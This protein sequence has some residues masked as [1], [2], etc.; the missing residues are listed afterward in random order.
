M[1]GFLVCGVDDSRGAR[2]AIL[3]AN[4]IAERL[5]AGLVLVHVAHV[6]VVPGASAVPNGRQELRECTTRDARVL[7]AGVAAD[8]GFAEADQRVE[9]GD[10]VHELIRVAEQTDALMLVVGSRGRGAL[11]AALLGSVSLRLCRQAPCPVLV[12]PPD[13]AVSAESLEAA[14]AETARR[15]LHI[16]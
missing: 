7:L 9:L 3:C 11:R 2:A 13:A 4:A 6:P 10:P 15:P 5:A 14:H 12:V 8:A 16:G 1:S